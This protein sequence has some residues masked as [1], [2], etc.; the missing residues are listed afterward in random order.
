MSNET[1]AHPRHLSHTVA[2]RPWR[3]ALV[4]AAALLLPSCA[5]TTAPAAETPAA[6]TPAAETP[7]A[8][9]QGAGQLEL[10]RAGSREQRT[11]P[12][13]NFTGHVVVTPLFSATPHTR[14][15]GASVQFD[16]GAHS[17]WHTHP[18][19][20]TLIVTE[21][22]GWVQQWG[23]AKLEIRPGDVIW[24]PPGVKRWHGATAAE[25]MS[26]TAIQ[27]LVDGSA[28][29]W[30]EHVSDEQYR[31]AAERFSSSPDGVKTAG[32]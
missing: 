20:Q 4:A 31:A 24:T 26:H 1:L 12:S 28:V 29:H 7:A 17:A 30:L 23:G 13:E 18:A 21:G 5:R 16:P 9:E 14:A 25:S 32:W 19:G 15:T 2:A 10:S 11:G 22:T 27:E 6:E 3:Y 8:G